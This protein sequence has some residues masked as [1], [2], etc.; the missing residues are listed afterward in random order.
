MGSTYLAL[1]TLH[2]FGAVIFLGNIIVTG[3]WK[4]MADR[5]KDPKIIAFAQ[6]QVILTDYVFTGGGVAIILVSGVGNAMVHGM[7]YWS[8]RWL[9]WGLWLFLASGII[10]LA[11]LIPVQAKQARLA[12]EFAEG[13]TISDEYWYLGRLWLW[14]GTAA[15]LL[16]LASLYWMVYKPA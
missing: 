15:T 5:T 14:F 4:V 2:V 6:R 12:R 13:G 1:K 7:D 3:W 16:P 9:A 8:I 11:I 10:W